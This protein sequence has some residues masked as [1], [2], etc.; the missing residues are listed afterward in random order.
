MDEMQFGFVI[1][2]RPVR[3]GSRGTWAAMALLTLETITVFILSSGVQI[4]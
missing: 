3:R 1:P 4:L 2:P